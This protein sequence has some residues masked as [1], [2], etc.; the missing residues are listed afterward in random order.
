VWLAPCEKRPALG[1][2]LDWT[3]ETDALDRV[4][5]QK[6]QFEMLILRLAANLTFTGLSPGEQY[7]SGNS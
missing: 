7:V 1:L 2:L 6:L 5:E 4:R 3:T